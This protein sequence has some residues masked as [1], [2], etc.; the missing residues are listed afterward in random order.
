MRAVIFFF[1]FFTFAGSGMG[2]ELVGVMRS[3]EGT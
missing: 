1:S 3:K 2:W